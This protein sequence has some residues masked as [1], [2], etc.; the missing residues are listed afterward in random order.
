MQKGSSYPRKTVGMLP[1]SHP[2]MPT[3]NVG[4]DTQQF[5]RRLNDAAV[6][7][8]RGAMRGLIEEPEPFPFVIDF[9]QIL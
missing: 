6:S 7:A 2:S 3:I 4:M 5:K 9:T 8:I 1:I